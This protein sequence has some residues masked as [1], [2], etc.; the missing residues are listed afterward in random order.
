MATAMLVS[1]TTRTCSICLLQAGGHVH[2]CTPARLCSAGL[3][4]LAAQGLMAAAT[5]CGDDCSN[6]PG[7]DYARLG[8]LTADFPNLQLNGSA[9]SGIC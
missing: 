1:C 7:C 5:C 3:E 4:A 6:S 9:G 2:C 8:T